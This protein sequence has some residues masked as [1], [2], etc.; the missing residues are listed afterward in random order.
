MAFTLLGG[1]AL[2]CAAESPAAEHATN[3]ADPGTS[4]SAPAPTSAPATAPGPDASAGAND[5]GGAQGDGATGG[6]DASSVAGRP[7][8]GPIN[9]YQT[10]C[11]RCHGAYGSGYLESFRKLSAEK[12]ADRIAE[13]TEGPA[14][15]PLDGEPLDQQ[16]RL[17]KALQTGEPFVWIASQP[18]PDGTRIEVLP[19]TTLRLKTADGTSEIKVDRD[20]AMLPPL[21]RP[22]TLIATRDGNTANVEVKPKKVTPARCKHGQHRPT[23]NR[24]HRCVDSHSLPRPAQLLHDRSPPPAAWRGRAWARACVGEGAGVRF[25]RRGR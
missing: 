8:T 11:A 20:H 7:V 13:M 17:H 16:I 4:A 22:A 2:M 18:E 6:D 25:P 19:K 1:T 10:S 15:A 23:R 12:L 14:Q 21:T 24:R 9:Y 3:Q 5:G